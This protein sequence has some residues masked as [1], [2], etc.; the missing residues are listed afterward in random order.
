[1]F[2]YLEYFCRDERNDYIQTIDC[3]ICSRGLS[4]LEKRKQREKRLNNSSSNNVDSNNNHGNDNNNS[5]N[6]NNNNNKGVTDF[7]GQDKENFGN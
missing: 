4:I 7:Y 6:D 2:V 5:N 3:D 1:M